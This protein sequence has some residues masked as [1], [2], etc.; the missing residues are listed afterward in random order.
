MNERTLGSQPRT[1][2]F[3]EGWHRHISSILGQAHPN[4][5]KFLEFLK[6]KV[7]NRPVNM[8]IDQTSGHYWLKPVISGRLVVDWSIEMTLVSSKVFSISHPLFTGPY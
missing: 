1:T 5:W 2:N 8:S 7:G 6:G 4:I 3:L